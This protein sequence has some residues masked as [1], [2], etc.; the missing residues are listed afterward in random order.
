GPAFS[1][2]FLSG[3]IG[4]GLGDL[5]LFYALPRI[6]ARLSV[7]IIQCL[8]APIGAILD[9]W[10]LDTNPGWKSMLAGLIILSGVGVALFPE[11]NQNVFLQNRPENDSGKTR[12]RAA[13]SA[14]AQSGIQKSQSNQMNFVYLLA[15]GA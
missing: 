10:W 15:I 6:G 7:L 4:L 14:I 11:K 12:N 8:A 3:M 5:F 1:L 13:S 9:Y 2:F